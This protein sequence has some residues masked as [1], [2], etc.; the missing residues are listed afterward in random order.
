MMQMGLDAASESDKD[1]VD[2]GTQGGG[3][4][5]IPNGVMGS[6]N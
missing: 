2:S 3:V 4:Y 1:R 5:R 6:S